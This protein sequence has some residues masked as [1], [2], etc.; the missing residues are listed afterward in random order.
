VPAPRRPLD[1]SAARDSSAWARLEEA[2]LDLIA[3]R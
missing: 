2:T 3:D 1:V